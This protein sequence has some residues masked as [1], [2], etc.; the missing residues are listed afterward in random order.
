LWNLQSPFTTLSYD[1]LDRL[2]RLDIPAST[3]YASDGNDIIA[4]YD[5]SNVLQKRYAFDGSGQPL[6]QYD[7]AGNRSWMLS[8]ERGSVVALAN[9]T[10]AMT[11]IDTYDEYGIP[12]ATNQGTF[13]YAGQMWLSRPGTYAPTYRALFA[14]LGRFGQ[15]DPIGFR[16]GINLYA[17]VGGDPVNR[18]DPLGLTPVQTSGPD[19]VV[20]GVRP[21]EPTGLDA[22]IALAALAAA[23]LD[24][25][26]RNEQT[27]D[28][29]EK[30]HKQCPPVQTR[31]LKGNTR[32]IG[33]PGGF[34]TNSANINVT[35]LSAAIIPSE[36]DMTKS[37]LRPYLGE[38]SGSIDGILLFS[39]VT[40]VI[41]NVRP[42][43]GAPAN[44]NT[45]QAF[46][47][48][49]HGSVILEVVG[50]PSD[51]NTQNVV[52]SVPP[53]VNCPSR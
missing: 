6:V 11:A 29:N 3:L 36:F 4:E 19:I 32:L 40:D 28:P 9:D 44:M 49:N 21:I 15:T 52:F 38:I 18:T 12:S 34:S 30:Q 48:L 10:A 17:Y 1:A 41:D 23:N 22:Y 51:L 43:R 42:P 16:G 31:V 39:G 24:V 27:R 7:A 37:Q 53:Q 20:T 47:F 26:D 35:N 50:I 8:D 33:K 5:G 46:E 14:H 45:R 25:N 2:Q 13:Q